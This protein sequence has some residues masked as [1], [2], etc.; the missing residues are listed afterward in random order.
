[1]SSSD[2]MVRSMYVGDKKTR[3]LSNSPMLSFS[4]H[5]PILFGVGVK[6]SWRGQMSAV[7]MSTCVNLCLVQHGDDILFIL[8]Q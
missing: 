1:M 8:T 3:L 5:T 6:E 4:T 7:A 2:I